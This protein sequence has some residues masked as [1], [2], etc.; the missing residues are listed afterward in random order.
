MS[1]QHGS[2]VNHLYANM[3]NGEPEPQV[4]MGATILSYTDR[5]AATVIGW[6]GEICTVQR[7]KATLLNKGVMSDAQEYSYERDTEGTTYRFKKDRSGKWR[8]VY[9]SL[10]KRWCFAEGNGLMLGRRE[11]YYDYSF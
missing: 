10:R 8:T 3:T 7:D 6:D 5:H 2:L 1:T 4:G 9:L 11:E